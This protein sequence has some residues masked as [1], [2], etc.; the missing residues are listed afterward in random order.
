MNICNE[1]DAKKTHIPFPTDVV[2]VQFFV[3][4]A[5]YLMTVWLEPD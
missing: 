5:F 2:F 3:P 1:A 4:R